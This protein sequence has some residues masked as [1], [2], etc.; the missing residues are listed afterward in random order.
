M[1]AF[2]DRFQDLRERRIGGA[3]DH[4]RARHHALAHDRLGE[5][6]DGVQHLPLFFPD[7]PVL[8]RLLDD[9]LEFFFGQSLAAQ[10]QEAADHLPKRIPRTAFVFQR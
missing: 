10:R 1:A 9:L 4:V 3:A 6:E 2:D 5:L 7:D 8:L